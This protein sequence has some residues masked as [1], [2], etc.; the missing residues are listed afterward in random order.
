M[1]FVKEFRNITGNYLLFVK[2][3]N[4]NIDINL[5]K[6]WNSMKPMKFMK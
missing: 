5:L 6:I 1:K 4:D 2:E 3:E